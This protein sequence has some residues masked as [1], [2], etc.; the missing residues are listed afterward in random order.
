MSADPLSH[1]TL[2]SG[3]EPPMLHGCRRRPLG[4]AITGLRTRPL[5]ALCIALAALAVAGCATPPSS[6]GG[7]TLHV[8]RTPIGETHFW[9]AQSEDAD[10]PPIHT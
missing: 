6:G 1:I 10:A 2:S 9:G 5:T 4:L 8:E 3:G 7:Q